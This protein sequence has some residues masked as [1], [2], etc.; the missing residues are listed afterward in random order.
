MDEGRTMGSAGSVTR[1][2]NVCRWLQRETAG[3]LRLCGS[4]PFLFRSPEI[5]DRNGDSFC[6]YDVSG[7]PPGRIEEIIKHDWKHIVYNKRVFDSPS[8][9]REKGKPVVALWG[10]NLFL[11]LHFT[12][13][14]GKF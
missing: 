10:D 4:R 3:C 13:F 6:R 7:V 14:D 5:A 2:V 12:V 8:Y 11:Y 1:L 9:L